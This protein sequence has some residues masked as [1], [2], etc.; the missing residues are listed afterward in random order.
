MSLSGAQNAS[1]DCW[2]VSPKS[3]GLAFLG[4]D[5]VVVCL[6]SFLLFF[7][8]YCKWMMAN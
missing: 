8:N 3:D 4:E 5:V 1:S 7:H 2:P 6:L